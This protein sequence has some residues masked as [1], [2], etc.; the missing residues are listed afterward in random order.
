[1]SVNTRAYKGQPVPYYEF[2]NGELRRCI[3]DAEDSIR[4]LATSDHQRA[5]WAV[6]VLKENIRI[7]RCVMGGAS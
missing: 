6:K 7:M 2:N 3:E 1:M 4:K 5:A